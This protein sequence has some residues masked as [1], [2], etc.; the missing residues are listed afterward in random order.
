MEDNKRGTRK[1]IARKPS[2]GHA[3]KVDY[4]TSRSFDSGEKPHRSYGDK[5]RS[6]G[7]DR[8]RREGEE[9]PRRPG[10]G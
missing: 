3:E 9:R 5:S 7:S 10:H 4:S 1:R 2:E 6:Y 8:P